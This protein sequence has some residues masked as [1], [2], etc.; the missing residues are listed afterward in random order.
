MSIVLD[1]SNLATTGVINSATAV[2][3]TSGTSIDFTSLPAGIKRITVMMSS[4]NTSGTSNLQLQLGAGSVTTS[5]YNC[6]MTYIVNG[7]VSTSNA[8]TGI[9]INT[10]VNGNN[11][12]SQLVLNTLGSNKWVGSVITGQDLSARALFGVGSITLSGT[13]DRVRITTV[14][15]TDTFSAGSVNILYE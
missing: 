10:A 2:A 15:G 3:S 12:T 7:T 11:Y 4:V 6:V 5:G 14:N 9:L 13:L 8:T 1:G